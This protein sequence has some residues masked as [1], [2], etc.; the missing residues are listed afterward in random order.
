MVYYLKYSANFLLMLYFV[1]TLV[2]VT[3]VSY[4]GIYEWKL[5][6]FGFSHR[7][8][9]MEFLVYDPMIPVL[10]VSFKLSVI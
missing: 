3:H 10:Y 7:N 2:E 4:K 5:E 8:T 9:L 1:L 6:A